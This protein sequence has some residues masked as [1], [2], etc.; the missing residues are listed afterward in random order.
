MTTAKIMRW[1]LRTV[2]KMKMSNIP[3]YFKTLSTSDAGVLT[4][5]LRRG[6]LFVPIR[7]NPGCGERG[8]REK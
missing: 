7:C 6:V 3:M 4:P 8:G 5:P 2:L 1:I